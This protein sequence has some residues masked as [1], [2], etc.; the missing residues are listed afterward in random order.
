MNSYQSIIPTDM[1]TKELE[2]ICGD[3]EEAKETGSSQ[4]IVNLTSNKLDYRVD[5]SRL[6]DYQKEITNRLK[7]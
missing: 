1:T 7:I 2:S 3:I 4:A 6:Q 5:V